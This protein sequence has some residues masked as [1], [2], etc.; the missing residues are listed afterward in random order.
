MSSVTVERE[1]MSW[2]EFEKLAADRQAEY[3]KRKEAER[4]A[5]TTQSPSEAEYSVPTV[6]EGICPKCKK[7]PVK[8]MR[9]RAG[10]SSFGV[11]GSCV[12]AEAERKRAEEERQRRAKLNAE[13]DGRV[14]N[15]RQLLVDCGVD[16]ESDHLDA[17]LDN[18]DPNPD[19]EALVAAQQFVADFRRGGRPT[20]FLYSERP[21]DRIA[22]GGG[23]THLA[24]AILRELLLSGDVDPH[25]ARHLRETRMTITIRG[26][27]SSGSPEEY[28]DDLMR[29]DL[30]ILDD[31]GKAKTD[32]AYFRELLFELIAGRDPRAT[33]ITSNHSPGELE[34]RDE[35]YAPLLSRILGKGPAVCLSGP[36]RRLGRRAAR[37]LRVAP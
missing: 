27:I 15:I 23:K 7:T 2:E 17:T 20:L 35:W 3:L 21:G 16:A 22:P 31:V 30:L 28:I 33:I 10:N 19:R 34:D 37:N 24:A 14:R 26:Q 36:D 29:R 18:F 32:S 25:T 1:E 13:R 11:C 12:E 8:G 6:I 9:D 4:A 5:S